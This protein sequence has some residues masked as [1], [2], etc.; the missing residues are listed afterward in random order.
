MRICVR[1]E[2]PNPAFICDPYI[3][4]HTRT[5]PHK[6]SNEILQMTK[7]FVCVRQGHFY[8]CLVRTRSLHT[9][10]NEH[11]TDDAGRRT[12]TERRIRVVL[13]NTTTASSTGRAGRWNTENFAH[14]LAIFAEFRQR[15]PVEFGPCRRACTPFVCL[16]AG[17]AGENFISV[18]VA[19]SLSSSSSSS[20]V[21]LP[22]TRT[23]HAYAHV[24]NG[25]DSTA[26]SASLV[27]NFT[28]CA[29]EHN[30]L[31]ACAA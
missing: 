28:G 2:P 3:H 1:H 15:V 7:A 18:V 11:V 13:Y 19:A 29:H 30:S 16:L 21:D 9:R 26:A 24:T 22:R 4:P 8:G 27:D 17:R 10:A 31:V 12:P 6:Y 25:C 5:P 23:T 20:L 14:A